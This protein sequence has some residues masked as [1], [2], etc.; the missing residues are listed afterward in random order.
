MQ[1]E[2]EAVPDRDTEA[3]MQ[4]PRSGVRTCKEMG[5]IINMEVIPQALEGAGDAW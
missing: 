1:V 2:G 3:F 4:L 5:C